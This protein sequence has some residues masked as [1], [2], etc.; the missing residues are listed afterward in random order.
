[1]VATTLVVGGALDAVGRPGAETVA[2]AIPGARLALLDAV[3]HTPHLEAPGVFA[4]LVI[5]FLLEDPPA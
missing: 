5:D 4:R 3:G 1:V 2:A